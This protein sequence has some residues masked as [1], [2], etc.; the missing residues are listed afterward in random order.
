MMETENL[1]QNIN[2]SGLQGK[3]W[4]EYSRFNPEKTVSQKPERSTPVKSISHS[5]SGLSNHS[6][7]GYSKNTSNIPNG[8]GIKSYV[9]H[10][11][12]SKFRLSLSLD[13]T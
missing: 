5:V 13:K 9:G 1:L 8:S 4:P 12:Q 6:N 7:I 11:L 3:D 2:L 10:S